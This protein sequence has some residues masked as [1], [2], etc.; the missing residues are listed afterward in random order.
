MEIFRLK[1]TL[2]KLNY[3]LRILPF[4]K[5]ELLNSSLQPLLP[6]FFSHIPKCTYVTIIKPIIRYFVALCTFLLKS[7]PYRATIWNFKNI[8]LIASL[9]WAKSSR[10]NVGES[11]LYLIKLLASWVSIN[12]QAK[13]DIWLFMNSDFWNWHLQLDIY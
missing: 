8:D 7:S 3:W 2:K 5:F 10:E 9:N 12:S 4:V 11:C 6:H 13:K 1:F